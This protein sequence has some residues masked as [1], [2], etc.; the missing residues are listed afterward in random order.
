MDEDYLLLPLRSATSPLALCVCGGGGA[1]R[2]AQMSSALD[3]K[4]RECAARFSVQRAAD[5]Y[6]DVLERAIR[7][8]AVAPERAACPTERRARA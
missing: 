3:D 7:G 4:L 5:R 1:A 2:A 6:L 8:R